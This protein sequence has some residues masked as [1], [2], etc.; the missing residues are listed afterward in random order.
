MEE[1]KEKPLSPK[2][3]EAIE[4]GKEFTDKCDIE[5]KTLHATDT[6]VAHSILEKLREDLEERIKEY[7]GKLS[8]KKIPDKIGINNSL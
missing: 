1:V 6:N 8:T 7:K 4:R 5:D 3:A 2:S